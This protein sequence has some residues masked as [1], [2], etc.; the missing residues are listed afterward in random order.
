[1][2]ADGTFG[3]S[4]EAGFGGT[5]SFTY[6]LSDGTDTVDGGTVTFTVVGVNRALAVAD[7]YS[8]NVNSPLAVDAAFGILANDIEPDGD[9]MLPTVVDQP[10]HGTLLLAGDGTFQYTPEAD[11]VGSDS[12]SY[13]LSDG[14]LDSA[15]AVVSLTINPLNT[16][17]VNENAARGTAVGTVVAEA[18]ATGTAGVRPAE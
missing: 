8:L 2:N 13:Q 5:D 11:Y 12:F 10:I 18:A 3:V 6:R 7:A 4:P 14:D 16:F 1:M 9:T 15:V 17:N